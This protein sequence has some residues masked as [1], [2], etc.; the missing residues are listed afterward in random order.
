[1]TT[2]EKIA[3]L[4]N[5]Y[6]S[7]PSDYQDVV[8]LINARRR[9]SAYL[10]FFAEQVGQLGKEKARSEWER[11]STFARRKQE[12]L[13][14]MS[15]PVSSLAESKAESELTDLRRAESL[16]EGDFHASRMIYESAGNVLD[17][18]SQHI[19]HLRRELELE[20]K[21]MGSQST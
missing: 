1:M 2:H 13:D 18:M 15:K 16:A 10:F 21:G 5:W 4:I 9:L 11:K 3:R 12:I 19:A 6:Y 20:T 17:A 7:L 14:T 8:M